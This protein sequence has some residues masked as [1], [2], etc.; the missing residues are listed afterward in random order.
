MSH[1]VVSD[2]FAYL[3]SPLSSLRTIDSIGTASEIPRNS[4]ESDQGCSSM[5]YFDN[6]GD[7][8]ALTLYNVMLTSQKSCLHNNKCDCSK[9]NGYSDILLKNT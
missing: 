6:A 5:I 4:G 8:V 9:A 2:L 3:P 7:N 1:I